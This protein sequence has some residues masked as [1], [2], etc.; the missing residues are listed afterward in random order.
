[1]VD[2][3]RIDQ[4]ANANSADSQP[5]QQ[6]QQQ[7]QHQ[8]PQQ[9]PQHSTRTITSARPI[10]PPAGSSS[11][12][13]TAAPPWLSIGDLYG[14]DHA[15]FRS[16]YVNRIRTEDAPNRMHRYNFVPFHELLVVTKNKLI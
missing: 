15:S 4:A 5:E 8:Q 12:G 9:P 3:M 16:R 10:P 13:N 14:S 1:M 6:Q 2:Q 7:Q 11:S